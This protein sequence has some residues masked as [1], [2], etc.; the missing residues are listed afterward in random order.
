MP[1]VRS[2]IEVNEGEEMDPVKK[3]KSKQKGDGDSGDEEEDM[4]FKTRIGTDQTQYVLTCMNSCLT[5]PLQS[6]SLLQKA[7]AVSQNNS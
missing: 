5:S 2:E 1:Q 3:M 7:Q 6:L 4:D